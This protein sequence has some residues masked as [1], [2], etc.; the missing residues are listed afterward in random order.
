MDYPEVGPG[1]Y[2]QYHVCRL[3]RGHVKVIL[4]GQGGDEVFV[5][6]PL[7][8]EV[9]LENRIANQRN[10]VSRLRMILQ[11]LNF[12]RHHKRLKVGLKRLLDLSSQRSDQGDI[13]SR[14]YQDRLVHDEYELLALLGEN[15][16]GIIGNYSPRQSFMDVFN[17]CKSDSF[18][19]RAQHYFIKTYLT[20]LLHVEDRTSMAVSL[21]S[22]VPLCCDHRLL[23]FAASIPASQRVRGLRLKHALRE[24]A[25]GEI[26]DEVYQRTDKKGFP[27]P[28]DRWLLEQVDEVRGIILSERALRRGIFNP[29]ALRHILDEFERGS[30]NRSLTVFMLL[31][32]EFWFRN[33]ID[34]DP[35]HE[36]AIA[37]SVVGQVA[38]S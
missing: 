7:F 17:G 26:P 15:F 29:K 30:Q 3:A 1:I 8:I 11:Y 21:E 12:E 5:G 22:R 19:D 27:T 28:F 33:F 32:L 23:E 20:G 25:K 38:E 6:Y 37:F 16:K 18:L 35:L 10:P 36:E 34:K 2:P 14:F 9:E 31:C 13:A 24:V 4:G